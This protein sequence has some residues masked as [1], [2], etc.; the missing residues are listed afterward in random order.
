MTEGKLGGVEGQ[1]GVKEAC[2]VISSIFFIY[3]FSKYMSVISYTDVRFINVAAEVIFERAAVG[4]S[5]RRMRWA[6]A[7]SA[8]CTRC[9]NGQVY[10][11]G[12][13]EGHRLQG[14]RGD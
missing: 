12:R 11:G 8:I 2:N 7:R 6:V 4:H 5:S 10:R 9:R 14:T 13:C 3:F 1:E